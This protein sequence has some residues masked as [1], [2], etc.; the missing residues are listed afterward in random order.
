M[1]FRKT[2]L[3]SENN[4]KYWSLETSQIFSFGDEADV[5]Y[6]HCSLWN[7]GKLHVTDGKIVDTWF[8]CVF[9]VL[10]AQ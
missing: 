9:L 8:Y 5:S 3:L 2:F 10:Y 1:L 6:S 4:T 7:G